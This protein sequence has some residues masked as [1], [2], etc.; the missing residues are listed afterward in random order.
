MTNKKTFGRTV[1][2]KENENISSALRR[3]KRKVEESGVL[4]CLR[5]KE[6]YIK[7]TTQRKKAMSTAKA[8]WR[9][10]LRDQQLPPKLY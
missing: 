4:D 5:D 2:V 7:P 3:L 8:R 1:T 6:G 10:H 9:K